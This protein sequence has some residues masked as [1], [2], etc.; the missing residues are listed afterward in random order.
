M[1]TFIKLLLLA[2]LSSGYCN[3]QYVVKGILSDT[4]NFL[5]LNHASVS[6]VRAKDSVIETF[7]R[8]G[9]DGS[10]ELR[11]AHE[12]KY[13]LRTSYPG[14]A[15]YIDVLD[16]KT[17][18]TDLGI[19]PV[20]SKEHLLKEFVLTKQI[21]AIKIKGD[22]T[23]YMADSFKTKANA[24]VE[25]LLKKLPGIQVDKDGKVTA[26]GEEVTKILVDG[27]EFFSDDPK[28]VTKGLQ[29]AAVNKVQV[30]DKKSEQA[31]FTGVDDGQKTKTINVELKENM[32]KGVF[33]KVD[34]GGGTDGFYQ[35]LGMLNAFKGKRQFTAFGIVSNTDKAGLG[36][37][38]RDKFGGSS[39]N[40]IVNDDGGMYTYY[41]GSDDFVGWDG[42]YNG[43]GLPKTITGGLHFA[44]KW[45][46]E[47]EHLSVNYRYASQG[48]DIDGRTTTQYILPGN[49]GSEQKQSKVQASNGFRHGADAMFEWKPDTMTSVKLT[50]EIGLKHMETNSLFTSGTNAN[51]GSLIN[52]NNR[53]ITSKTDA[54]FINSSLVIKRKFAKKGRTISLDMKENY[55]ETVTK[56][57][58][59]SA[60]S[61]VDTAH[62]SITTNTDQKKDNSSG[63]MVLSAKAIYTE[64]IS[65]LTSLD[66]NYTFTMNNSSAR[67]YSFDKVNGHYNDAP[68]DTFSSDYAFNVMTNRA[69][70]NFKYDNKTILVS[71]GSDISDARYQ[72]TDKLHGDKTASRD[73]FN[74]FPTANFR[75]KIGKQ[76]NF[77]IF[78][79]GSTQQPTLD[80]VQTF[81]QNTD[82][83]NRTIGNPDLRQSFTNRINASF[84]DYKALSGTHT[85]MSVTFSNVADAISTSQSITPQGN[86]TKYVN[87][88]GNYSASFF[89]NRG[90][91]IRKLNMY[92]GTHLNGQFNHS[93][94]FVNDSANISNNN[95][96]NYGNYFEYEKEGKYSFSWE[97]SVTY[98]DNRATIS[99]YGNSYWAFVNELSGSYQIT[100]KL[101]IGSNAEFYIRQR[102][103]VF[104]KN[105]NVVR[106][107]AFIGRKFLKNNELE[108]KLSVND[109]LNQ[110]IGYTRTAQNGVI[111]ENS[112][113]T[114]RRYGMLN[115]IWNFNHS[116]AA[117]A[118][119]Q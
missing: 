112:Y 71:V 43:E 3:A 75:Y 89:A 27:E 42:K 39:G 36:W 52:T 97:P 108:V 113:N 11:T 40:T 7:A 95:S 15:D 69:G 33:G 105:N 98:T 79:Q 30:F 96:Y 49:K 18:A 84:S 23:E 107:N 92:I 118:T 104:N 82:P 59:N 66:V 90:F 88:D 94:N 31:E 26:Q 2:L 28:V 77:N 101:E 44:N 37:E 29:A 48:V 64:P 111:T 62:A 32:K 56:G 114:I 6:L 60:L 41:S 78:Y 68:N 80:Q 85:Y 83:L 1:K 110:N 87:V 12:G 25:D 17:P 46:E 38:D 58:L 70:A 5:R 55:N 100:K 72:Q 116:P 10:F 115:V 76:T 21:A 74:L 16:I 65:K 20:M 47:K 54:Q 67:N 53:T 109:I 34:A 99:K 35:N 61:F 24:N 19:I 86:I 106:W 57:D 14:F 13:R 81:Q 91:R 63:K 22:T 51:D 119:A 45:N 103:E 50:T 8:T 4:L 117:A 9:V 93:H 102:T 73:Y